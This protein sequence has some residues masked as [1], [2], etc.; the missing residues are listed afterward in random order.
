MAQGTQPPKRPPAPLTSQK[1]KHIAS[2]GLRA[3]STITNKQTQELAASVMAH[4][5]PRKGQHPKR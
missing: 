2:E 4:I 3:P 1:I 5:E